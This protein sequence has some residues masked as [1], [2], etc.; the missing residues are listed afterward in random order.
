MVWHMR[1]AWSL[2][3]AVFLEGLRTHPLLPRGALRV[4]PLTLF[5]ATNS[6]SM[7]SNYLQ[8]LKS[9]QGFKS[10]LRILK[11][12]LQPQTLSSE[13][14]IISPQPQIFST[15][16]SLPSTDSNLPTAPN[17][18]HSL[19]L[20]LYGLS[21]SSQP[22]TLSTTSNILYSLKL[23][24][25]SHT[26]F[27]HIIKLSP[28][29]QTFSSKP[30]TLSTDNSLS[31]DMDTTKKKKNHPRAGQVLGTLHSDKILFWGGGT[32]V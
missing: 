25:Q 21:L 23:S 14:P 13:P 3:T 10:F 2:Y 12:S 15:A 4:Q 7:A 29:S 19:K 18:L 31:Q 30:Q 9:L 16:S 1:V 8:S 24:C 28:Q 22:Q 11:P 26:L 27:L 5:R 17:P 32:P 20:F 6:L